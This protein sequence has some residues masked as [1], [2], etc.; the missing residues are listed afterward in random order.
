MPSVAVPPGAT[1]P[2]GEPIATVQQPA[3]TSNGLPPIT[4]VGRTIDIGR[5]QG[6]INNEIP[7]F[8]PETFS[9]LQGLAVSGARVA[10]VIQYTDPDNG[11]PLWVTNTANG[12]QTTLSSDPGANIAGAALFRKDANGIFLPDPNDQFD[13]V[14]VLDPKDMYFDYGAIDAAGNPIERFRAESSFD[15]VAHEL[16]HPLRGPH[17][18]LMTAVA[19]G[20]VITAQFVLQND[21]VYVH[22]FRADYQRGVRLYD[23]TGQIRDPRAPIGSP[24]HITPDDYFLLHAQYVADVYN[25]NP[26]SIG[27]V[28]SPSRGV[29]ADDAAYLQATLELR[30]ALNLRLDELRIADIENAG[31][32]GRQ[33][34]SI[35]GNVLPIDNPF[36]R[37]AAS[38]L[39][40]TI[41]ENFAEAIR[42]GGITSA[43]P[44]SEIYNVLSNSFSELGANLF[45]GGVG[46][47]S[48]VLVADLI[49][50]FGL[51]GTLYGDWLQ[52][53]WSAYVTQ[54]ITHLPEVLSGNFSSLAQVNPAQLLGG[55]LGAQLASELV[56]FDT[57]GGQIGAAIGSTLGTLYG[58]ELLGKIGLSVAG[59]IGAFIGAFIGYIFG[60]LIGSLFGGKPKSGASIGWNEATQEYLVANVWSKNSGSKD[61]A[62]SMATSV[63]ELL[64][65]VIESV[66]S[67][68]I[69]AAGVQVGAYET[70]GKDFI[71]KTS[72]AA[73]YAYRTN[74]FGK[75]ITH[76]QFIA[77][78]DLSTRLMG[79]DVYAKRAILATLAQS[80]GN[81]NS[82]NSYSAG[83]FT[84]NVLLGNI[85]VAESYRD[86]VMQP[87]II[88]TLIGAAGD[89]V[90]AAGWAITM[91]R[92][93][94][95]GLDKRAMSDW[96][97]GWAAFLDETG[98]GKIDGV[99]FAPAN[100][101]LSIAENERIFSFFNGSGSF[102]GSIGDTIDTAS[103]DVIV[104]TAG[105]DTLTVNV[106]TIALTTS[107][108][109]NGVAATAGNRKIRVAALIDGGAGDDTIRVGDLGNDLLGGEGADILVG[110]KLDDW[111]IGGDGADRLFAG[112]ASNISFA[113]GD[114]TAEN[115]ALGLDGGN[116][117]YLEGGL[118]DDALYGSRGSDWLNGGAG[119]DRLLGGAGGDVLAGGA[120]DERGATGEA[121]I[122]GGAG[123]DQYVFGFLDGK[124]VIFDESDPA[125]S[126]GAVDSFAQRMARFVAG[127]ETKN[128]A[129]G[130]Q[131][132]ENGDVRG[133]EDAIAFGPGITLHNL[134]MRRT[135]EDLLIELQTEINGVDVLTG[136]AITIKD[137]FNITR[138]VEWLR[139]ADGE[140][141]RIGDVTSFIAGTSGPD[142]IIGSFGADFI[143]GGQGNDE[144]RGLSGND[145]GFGG[146]GDDFVAGDSDNDM[147]AG[148]SGADEVVGGAGN[149]TVF[150]DGGNDDLYGGAGNDILAGGL[151]DDTIV[152]GAGDDIV[153]YH[154]GDGRDLV[155]DEFVN[156]WDVVWQ[157]GTYLNGYTPEANGTV[158][159]G[160]VIVFD[161]AK[162]IGQYDW[163]DVAKVL[164]RHKGALAG[165]SVANAG[166]DK[167]EFALGIDIQDLVLR[168]T[169]ADLEIAVG[170]GDLDARGFDQIADRVTV[171]DWYLSGAV[172]SIENF[173]FAEIGVF[174]AAG[175]TLNGGTDNS[176]T[177]AGTTGADWITGG[178]GDD[179]ITAN[180][181][182]DIVSGGQGLDALKG[183]AGADILYGGAGDDVLE[184]GAGIDQLFG[185]AGLDVAS[186][187]ASTV[188]I[189]ASLTARTAANGD[190]A[191]DVYDSIEGLEGSAYADKLTGDS[192]D[193]ILRGLAGADT[194][195]G[196]AG[197]DSY[198]IER[199]H[200]ADTIRD[201]LFT[202]EQVLD[203]AGNFNATDFTLTWTLLSTTVSGATTTRN[204][205]LVVT[206][207]GTSEQ[208]YRSRDNVD[209]VY[210]NQVQASAPAGTAWP[211]AN[212]QWLGGFARTGNVVQT[213]RDLIGAGEGGSDTIQFGVDISLSDL[214]ITRANGGADLSIAYNGT[215]AVTI[216]G[217]DNT[218]RRIETVTFAD[219]LVVDLTGLK[220]AGEA[221]TTGADFMFGTVAN[222]TID[223]LE[224]DDVISGLAGN[225]TLLG[226]A[227]D[228]ML[229]GG[230]GAD[231]LNGGDDAQTNNVPLTLGLNGWGDTVRYVRSTAAVT[232]DLAALTASGGHAASDTIVAGA[233][234]F[235]SIEHVVGSNTYGDTLL[236]DSRANRLFGLGGNDI[237]DGRAGDDVL[238]GGAGDDS[239]AGGDGADDLTGEVGNDTITGGLG[240]DLVFGGDGLDTISGNEDDDSIVGGAG[241]D[242]LHGD[243][244]ADTIGG[245]ADNDTI[246]GDAGADKLVG[247]DGADT[248]YGGAENDTLAGEA[249]NDT[250]RGEAGDDAYVFSA[251]G[252]A[253]TVI[254]ASGA[255][256]IVIADLASS[257]LWLTRV[258]DD[259]KISAIG[260]AEA[261]FSILVSG[262]YSGASP[263]RVRE[264]ATADASLFLSYDEPLIAA[265]TAAG[266]SAPATMPTTIAD[267]LSTY[268]HAGGKAAPT[269]ADASLAANED[270]SLAGAVF[271]VDHD[272]N[273]TSY[274]LEAAPLH[275]AVTVNAQTGAWAYTPA[276]DYHGADAFSV[277]VTDADGQSAVQQIAV[278]VTSVNDAP[279]DIT[280]TGAPASIVERDR[281]Q[282]GAT[283]DAI[284]LGTLSATDVDAPDAGDFDDIVF[285]VADARFEVFHDTTS[286]T[287]VLRLKAGAALDFEVGA[288]VDVV[289]T[290]TDRNGAGLTFTK[291]F[292]FAVTDA[293]DYLY[294]AENADT[295]TGQSG[296][297][298]ILGYGGADTITGGG[299]HDDLDGGDGA[300]IIQGLAGADMLIGGL[301]NDN[302]DGGLGD[303]VLNAGDGDDI[304]LGGAGA[305]QLLGGAGNDT[306]E[307]GAG[308]DRFDGGAGFDTVTYTGAASGI[309]VNLATLNGSGGD[310]AGDVFEEA[311]E[312]LI[313][314]GFADTLTG[315]VSADHIRGGAGNDVMFGG[316]GSDELFGEA[317]DDTI[318][319]EL[320]DDR[321]FGGAGNDTL[322]GGEGNDTYFVNNGD[323]ADTIQ[324]FDLVGVDALSFGDGIQAEDLWFS[325]AGDDLIITAIDKDASVRV[326]NWFVEHPSGTSKLDYLFAYTRY[327]QDVDVGALVSLMGA[328]YPGV[329]TRAQFDALLADPTFR[330]NW[331]VRWQVNEPPQ[332]GA[333]TSQPATEDQ[334]VVLTV[335]VTDDL[336]LPVAFSIVA[337]DSAGNL[338]SDFVSGPLTVA[339]IGAGQYEVRFTPR[340]HLSG[341]FTLTVLASDLGNLTAGATHALAIAPIADQS[342][343]VSRRIAGNSR[344][345]NGMTNTAAIE[346]RSAENVSGPR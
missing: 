265:M 99:A 200:G 273:I 37:A 308:A 236:G 184:G 325:R 94:E 204:Y 215:N 74:D 319:A 102:L 92:A 269:L 63:A 35:L 16:L 58:A 345:A 139:F 263:S 270:T 238:V 72:A 201:G 221:A 290:A 103:K 138:R 111:L 82:D 346:N 78:S 42:A 62:R 18:A 225:D 176:E 282:A 258:G 135:G 155:L 275:G 194:L 329:P 223:G 81:P 112:N 134:V 175:Y 310:A 303:D 174:N 170:S 85:A 122:L 313:G 33:F 277:R 87:T 219:G 271:A 186:Y 128:W 150:G 17:T 76:G 2:Y 147:V 70:K 60:G 196:G 230:A 312:W 256:K 126:V 158:T 106:D 330:A 59:P 129:G 31:A 56:E 311:P 41:G 183:Q 47:I 250:L 278:V 130:G 296:R 229:E 167:L 332:L 227:G 127:T 145:Y 304:V 100:V 107:H 154:R 284:V 108:T 38:A 189:T 12:V 241:A 67:R 105:A 321:L 224:G 226:G 65:G 142:V 253:D 315:T 119:A 118:G 28:D 298:I 71:Y 245:D 91:A 4:F 208:I 261:S 220:L 280:L 36:E 344:T 333:I 6:V 187:A 205:Q 309:V 140:D 50:S 288:S 120:G 131:Y 159:I 327:N 244:G 202:T 307:G 281:P 113:L 206:K 44:S 257:Q 336:P 80:G 190:G 14:L 156:N 26:T 339:Q 136:D 272:E 39:I 228:D 19:A 295:L 337:R 213:T 343:Q 162:W 164:R 121:R 53:E 179:V 326:T 75:V 160:G 318:Q 289:I 51:D 254:D 57:I 46:T 260:L 340:A 109:L 297:N 32:F 117:D 177:V 5:V 148:G 292:T 279:S 8:S 249:G 55:F 114:A 323:G 294:G 195:T 305:D 171:R 11:Q 210:I 180:S 101:S 165:Q 222:N 316:A 306:L 157:N 144:I 21:L 216:Q 169:G 181:G 214:V 301:G 268:W 13:V 334:Q 48:S 141:V 9:V 203:A 317:G 98:G 77:L 104:A 161:G 79:G 3:N 335:A 232:I 152:T 20:Q 342:L 149:D 293:D 93:I 240:K 89:S 266:A 123:S 143:V 302:L 52:T 300:D 24:Q 61:A 84:T 252:G 239:L 15:V 68:V 132:L 124:D 1:G 192:G 185:G 287:Y 40:A 25:G 235:A 324:N 96:I 193:N 23:Q 320:G 29:F 299:G 34:A 83:L 267:T 64:N 328:Q 285:S 243:A 197:D 276:L 234:G 247:G 259:L 163:D 86:Y 115:A 110:G 314:S 199:T 264:I 262:Y 10:I 151:G 291:T 251:A 133:G 90:F 173:V 95:L 27:P 30:N 168:R 283:L 233:N 43:L 73:S 22:S 331:M 212:G 217:Q 69:D 137:W 237:M 191:G 246:Y 125:G 207:T 153:R 274:A 218:E 178:L 322:I 7:T 188:A 182:N 116:G 242:I 97:G 286:N 255:N 146:G 54:I 211:F 231:A 45:Q 209:F 166:A 172:K 338:V 49:D 66:G 88:N 198:E 248:L 341:A